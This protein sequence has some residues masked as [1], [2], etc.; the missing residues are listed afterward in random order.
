[1]SEIERDAQRDDA[2]VA[3]YESD[4]N[5]IRSST[6]WLLGAFGGLALVVI[7]GTQFGD[8]SSVI[9]QGDW[10]AY[11]IVI[12]LLVVFVSLILL[13]RS[14]ARVLVPDRTNLTDLI[15]DQ[16]I[17]EARQNGLIVND[18]QRQDSHQIYKYIRGEIDQARGWL[19]PQGCHDLDAAY[20]EYQQRTTENQVFLRSI[21]KEI[22]AFARTEAALYRYKQ[23]LKLLIERAGPA[24]LLGLIALAV[25]LGSSAQDGSG[26]RVREPFAVEVHFIGSPDVLENAGI[27][28]NCAVGVVK[29]IA[30]GETIAEP[31]VIT[32]GTPTC[33]ATKIRIT[34]D[35][36]I[37]MPV[38]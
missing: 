31:E 27:S 32:I 15:E 2:G 10:R 20:Q 17:E 22:M 13:A 30:V 28:V 1:M 4:L 33:P 12:A 37:A 34:S 5:G 8:A 18:L 35:L 24:V 26:S 14:A 21:F 36:G 38:L 3:I 23:L 16:A 6:Q 19:L 7:A 9:A 25:A 11:V 29:G